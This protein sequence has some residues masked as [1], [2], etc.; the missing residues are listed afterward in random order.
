VLAATGAPNPPGEEPETLR[1]AFAASVG[2]PAALKLDPEV[3][4]TNLLLT[5]FVILF[6]AVCSY[7]FNSTIDENRPTIVA[8]RQKV[9]GWL[10]PVTTPLLAVD[11]SLKGAV[12]N[13]RLTTFARVAT[14]LVLSAV[15]Y[16]FLDPNFGLNAASVL[17]F[18]GMLIGLGIATYLAEGGST[19]LAVRRYKAASSVR[20]LGA[21][22]VVAIACVLASRL[23]DFRPGFVFGFIASSVILSPIV[24]SKKAAAELVVIPAVL[25]L[26]VAML[27]W[28]A[29]TPIRT[30]TA[31]DSAPI[32]VLLETILAILFIGGLEAVAFSLLPLSFMDGVTVWRWNKIVWVV[33]FGT[34]V[35]LFWQL[36]IN[37]EG[38]YLEAFRQSS[39]LVCIALVVVYGGLT[40]LT[41][42]YFRWRK[43]RENQR[44]AATA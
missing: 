18:F 33:L 42:G 9:S 15:I 27:A 20:L 1:S 22:I 38:K 44:E 34:S 11:R 12:A 7:I 4:L 21:G 19:F 8:W 25:T 39:V 3:V 31:L 23:I 41:W 14:V 5:I 13:A 17:L 16:G 36:V 40:L 24:L 29:L 10:W 37:R 6:V 2:D 30:A 32:P 26:I 28:T 43:Y 35:F